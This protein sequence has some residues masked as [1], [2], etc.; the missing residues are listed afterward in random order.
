MLHQI[1]WNDIFFGVPLEKK[2]Y[3]KFGVLV[4]HWNWPKSRPLEYWR[5]ERFFYGRIHESKSHIRYFTN[6]LNFYLCLERFAYCYRHKVFIVYKELVD[7]AA[8]HWRIIILWGSV[9]SK[10]SWYDDVSRLL[11]ARWVQN[12]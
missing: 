2:N 9:Q 6:S 7:P 11:L 1:W 12:L 5:G 10:S 3:N 4:S 8:L